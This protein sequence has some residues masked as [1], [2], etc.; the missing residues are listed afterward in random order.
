MAY[1][2]AVFG[3][4][5]SKAE[6]LGTILEREKINA[7]DLLYIGDQELDQVGAH[8][9]GCHFLGVT[10]SEEAFSFAPSCSVDNL[11]GLS[12]RD[13]QPRVGYGQLAWP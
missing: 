10:F 7:G 11:M 3:S 2:R 12:D 6:V 13:P 1:F 4:S 8:E 9:I 5:C